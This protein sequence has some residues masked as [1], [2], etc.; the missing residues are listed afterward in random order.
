[1]PDESIFLFVFIEIWLLTTHSPSPFYYKRWSEYLDSKDSLWIVFLCLIKFKIPPFDYK[2][3]IFSNR[4]YAICQM[5]GK[6]CHL[7]SL[8]IP[9]LSG[10]PPRGWVS[11]QRSR[12][13]VKS[14]LFPSPGIMV[15]A[16]NKS[17]Q[18]LWLQPVTSD[19]R[20]F[21]FSLWQVTAG[22]MASASDKWNQV[23]W[24]QP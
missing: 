8:A 1:M 9:P 6:T 19:T 11:L 20:S 17:R 5:L 13:K 21:G 4:K 22:L 16:S 2:T 12:H 15:S 24:L 14:D 23:L 10:E 18:V 3:T 7:F